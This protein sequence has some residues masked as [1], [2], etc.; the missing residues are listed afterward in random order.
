MKKKQMKRYTILLTACINPNGMAMTVLQDVEERKKQYINAINFYL[1]STDMAICICENTNEQLQQY[2]TNDHKFNDRLEFLIFDGNNYKNDYGKGY[3][4]MQIIQYAILHSKLIA[5]SDIIIKITGRLMVLNLPHLITLNRVLNKKTIQTQ[6][7]NG[8]FID[9]RLIIAPKDFYMQD[10]IP[11]KDKLSESKHIIF[12]NLLYDAI[13]NRKKNKYY[14]FFIIPKIEGQSGSY[15]YF[16]QNNISRKQ[17][18][19][20]MYDALGN[21]IRFHKR[22]KF[23]KKKT[24]EIIIIQL[25][26]II[27]KIIILIIK[28][29]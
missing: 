26:R 15:G 19:S 5:K 21:E 18:I 28:I 16:Y 1:K 25:I 27:L 6:F 23:I 24:Y 29:L 11:L 14:P 2:F 20:Y 4:E 22:C 9:S 17:Q 10:L 13:I 12:E 7:T 8:N 3:G